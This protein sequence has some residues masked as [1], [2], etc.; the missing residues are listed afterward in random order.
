[1]ASELSTIEGNKILASGNSGGS[2]SLAMAAS[3]FT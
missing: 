1:M 3:A 2:L